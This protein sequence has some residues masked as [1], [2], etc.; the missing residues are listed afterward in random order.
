MNIKKGQFL[1]PLDMIQ[2]ITKARDAAREAGAS[3][4]INYAEEDLKTRVKGITG[5]KG[6][7]V[8]YD[9]VGGDTFDESLRC[10]AWE[11]RLLVIDVDHNH[12]PE[13]AEDLGEIVSRVDAELNGLF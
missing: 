9:P 7:D 6:V 5:G 1:A 12:F 8:V 4:F 11:G 2:V 10:I 3:E 13:S